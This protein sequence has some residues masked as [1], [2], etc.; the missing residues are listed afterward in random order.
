[1]SLENQRKNIKVSERLTKAITSGKLSHA[2]IIEG[3]KF[4]DKRSFAL[5]F[6][7]AIVCKVKPGE[8]CDSCRSCRMIDEGTYRD[9]FNVTGDEKS[10]KDKDIEE[11]QG[12][13]ASLPLEEGGRNIAIIEDSDTMTTRAQ[14]RLLKS[15]EEPF[16]GTVIILLS[17]NSERLLPTIRSRCQIV[18]LYE[19]DEDSQENSEYIA[20]AKE[21]LQ[22]SRKGYFFEIRE[23]LKEGISDKN[24][25]LLLL[26]A[27]EKELSK[28]VMAGED[29]DWAA[30]GILE[31]ENAR[32]ELNYNVKEKYALGSLML[33]IGG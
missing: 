6:A 2:Y 1:M 31:I 19:R 3:D 16:P 15:L 33:K 12:K 5:D 29:I 24:S 21:L 27:M 30:K 28:M 4:S 25:A 9:L 18:R 11:L 13:L 8:G 23:A 22:L 17:E 32:K 7:K 14:N 20:L 10:V 26:D